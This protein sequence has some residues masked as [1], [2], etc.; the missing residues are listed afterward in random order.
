M[1][2]V[3][4]FKWAANPGDAKIREN[5]TTN[6][7]VARPEVGDDDSATIHA[8]VDAANGGEVVGLTLAGG[9][10]VAYAAARGAASTYAI[11]GLPVPV[12]SFTLAQAL[13][14]GVQAIGDVDVVTIGDSE[15]DP[16]VPPMVAALLGWP[17]I[18]MV[19]EVKAE[20]GSLL[21]TRRHGA[22]TQ[23]LRVDVPVVLGVAARREETDIP[24]MRVVLQAR[25]KP[26]TTVTVEELGLDV[27]AFT[28]LDTH[29]PEKTASCVYDGSDPE[30]AVGQLIQALQAE[31]AL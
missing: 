23:D 7:S 20:D 16:A 12:D 19:D 4:I 9:N 25:K 3:A 11:E 10:N 14:K 13:A 31:G 24:G 6:W 18:M 26:V 5:G 15:W 17:A 22:G 29:L 1:K 27:P 8:A 21:V 30:K 28:A 2:A